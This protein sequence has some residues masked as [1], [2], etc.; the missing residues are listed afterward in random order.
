MTVPFVRAD[1]GGREIVNVVASSGASHTVDLA[2]GNVHDVTLDANC[3]LTFAGTVADRACSFVLLLRQDA[4]GSH[5][6]T[7][8]GE[9]VWS[10]GTAPTLSDAADAIDIVTFF[11]VDNGTTWFGFVSGQAMA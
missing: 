3:T 4:T 8:P 11:T 7:W 5:T 9:V 2:D 6:V 1:A 10:D